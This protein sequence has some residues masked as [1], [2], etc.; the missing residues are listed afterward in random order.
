MD[1]TNLIT[2]EIQAVLKIFAIFVSVLHL[3]VALILFNFIRTVS[4]QV[5]TPSENI[6]R[7]MGIVHIGLLV[8][9][10]LGIIF[11]F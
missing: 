11:L 4:R 1:F 6:F 8:V 3:L 2:P 9:I 7:L 5:R 10:L